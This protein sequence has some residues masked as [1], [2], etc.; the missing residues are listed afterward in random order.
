MNTCM[1]FFLLFFFTFALWHVLASLCPM[2][3][4]QLI[5]FIFGNKRKYISKKSTINQCKLVYPPVYLYIHNT[6]I[7]NYLND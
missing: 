2:Q 3:Q 1:I 7:D 4:D 5:A 6:K